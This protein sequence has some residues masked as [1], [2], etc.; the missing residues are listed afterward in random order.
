MPDD[1]REALDV[2]RPSQMGLFW[3]WHPKGHQEYFN[4]WDS[5][6]YKWSHFLGAPLGDNTF[7]DVELSWESTWCEPTQEA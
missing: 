2:P 1:P 6:W 4:S 7:G 5:R 3:R